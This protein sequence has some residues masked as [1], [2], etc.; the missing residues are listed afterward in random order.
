MKTTGVYCHV[1]SG[2]DLEHQITMECDNLKESIINGID[3]DGDYENK[4]AIIKA[5]I[6][7]LIDE[8]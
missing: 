1:S 5:M 6:Q 8:L 7:T 4:K 2:Y 3:D